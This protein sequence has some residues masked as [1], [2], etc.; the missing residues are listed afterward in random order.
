MAGFVKGK[1]VVGFPFELIHKTDLTA[2]TTGTV[3][4]YITKDGG[5]QELLSNPFTHE[6]NG[7][8]TVNL[9]AAEMTADMIG[10]LFTHADSI[11]QHFTV[12]TTVDPPTV[13]AGVSTATGPS[14]VDIYNFYGTVPRANNYFARRLNTGTWDNAILDDKE[15]ALVMAARAIDKLNF[16]GDKAVVT[17]ELQFPRGDDT[18]VPIEIDQAGYEIALAF[19]DDYD[20]EQEAQTI[21]VVTEAYSGVRTT[22]DA[23]FVP[24]HT[25]AGI[26]SIEA[27]RLLKPF[28]RDEKVLRLSRVS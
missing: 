12:R 11:P 6:G 22:Y 28:L 18:I 20:L 7:Q 9:S 15:A 21:G 17:Q 1:A 2:I 8:Y 14:I 27:W 10:L 24:E 19:L 5:I 3:T 26:P 13:I 23:D 16:A 25:V 4:G